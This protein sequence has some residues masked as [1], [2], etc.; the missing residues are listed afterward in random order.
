MDKFLR[1]VLITM[2][3]LPILGPTQ[4]ETRS[5]SLSI[6]IL[7]VGQGDA[8]L[9]HQPGICSVLIDAGPL[10]N[11]YRVTKKLEEL[12]ID[13]LD[14]VIFTHPHL[15]HFGGLFDL[16]SRIDIK[17]FYDN[18][19]S[20]PVREYFS[21]Y[22][23]IRQHYDYKTISA[24][25]SLQFG[26]ILFEI[27]H[28]PADKRENWNLNGSSLVIMVSFHTFR[29]LHMGDLAGSAE[30]F[31]LDNTLDITADVLKIAHHGAADATSEMLLQRVQPTFAVISTSWDNWIDAPSPTVLARL[32]KI[33]IDYKRTD[34]GGSINLLISRNGE[35]EV[36]SERAASELK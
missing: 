25:D 16:Y 23:K 28:P 32:T 5:T 27:V 11:G 7:D 31:F 35:F 14:A 29:L 6:Y 22:E 13:Q 9:L 18:G 2:T 4:A 24:G 10:M 34:E 15:D 36:K 3:I 21:D 30:L 26:D 19:M 17:K 12:G 1:L 8:M 20:N 33:G